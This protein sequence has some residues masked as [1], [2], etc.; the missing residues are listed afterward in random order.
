MALPLALKAELGVG[1]QT[2]LLAAGRSDPTGALRASLDDP[3]VH[4]VVL[5]L[6]FGPPPAASLV[7][8]VRASGPLAQW[9]DLSCI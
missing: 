1:L 3:S 9:A 8:V 7:Q 5:A 2:L 4:G 6:Q